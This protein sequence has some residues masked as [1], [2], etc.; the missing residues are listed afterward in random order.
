MWE[1]TTAP[2]DAEHVHRRC[3]ITY[4]RDIAS[5]LLNLEHITRSFA[6]ILSRVDCFNMK[7]GKRRAA[8]GALFVADEQKGLVMI[9]ATWKGRARARRPA[10]FRSFL[11][12][13]SIY[14]REAIDYCFMLR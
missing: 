4:R 1:K 9:R 14:A 12:S 10:R 5:F 11:R 7:T 3:S 6:D 2:I 13:E 8:A